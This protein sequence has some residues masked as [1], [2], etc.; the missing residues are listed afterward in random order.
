MELEEPSTDKQGGKRRIEEKEKVE[1][2]ERNMK[3]PN[4]LQ[5]SLEYLK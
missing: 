2:F 1:S 5:I 3:T 4:I